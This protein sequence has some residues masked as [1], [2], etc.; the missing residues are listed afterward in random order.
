LAAIG[1]LEARVGS[2]YLVCLE[3][4]ERATAKEF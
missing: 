3:Y 1:L 4:R 2:S